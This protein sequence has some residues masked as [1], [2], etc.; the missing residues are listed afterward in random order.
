MGNPP[1]R[2]DILQ[3]VDGAE[4]ADIIKRHLRVEWHGVEVCLISREDL[5]L[6]KRAAGRLQDLVDA[7]N[8]E[9]LEGE[10]F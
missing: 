9:R 2:V 10:E 3:T 7:A 1:V 4:F 6:S 8:L 5:I